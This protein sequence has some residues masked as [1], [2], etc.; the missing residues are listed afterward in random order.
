MQWLGTQMHWSGHIRGQSVL[1][2]GLLNM[3][4]AVETIK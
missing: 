1:I 4:D 2:F 3:I